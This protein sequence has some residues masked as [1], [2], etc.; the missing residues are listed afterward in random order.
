[1]KKTKT[2]F[3]AL[4]IIFS[5]NSYSQN[6][7]FSILS[8]NVHHCNPPSKENFIDIAAIAK[9]INSVKPDLVALQ[10]IDVNTERSGSHINQAEELGRQTGMYSFFVKTIDFQGG[11]YGIAV[12]SKYPFIS[13]RAIELPMEHN[14]GGE[15]RAVAFVVVE[16]VEGHKIAFASTHF[17]LEE[18]NKKLQINSIIDY[19]QDINIPV[20]LAGDFNAEPDSYV[21]QAL[22]KV[23]QRT[24][25]RC[26]FTIPEIEPSH[27][28]DYIS[29]T[30]KG[31]FEVVKHEVINEDYASDHLPVFA[32]VK[33]KSND[34]KNG[35]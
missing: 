17:D 26:P 8:Y 35:W 11:A 1:M 21:I 22:D 29:F 25:I 34:A 13:T 24:C 9:V 6:N 12:L 14:A 15:P 4:F 28:I 19:V 2:V 3:F 5:V 10:E 7:E 32:I 20:I 27:T 18:E 23:F 16:P 33:K 30:P 31:S